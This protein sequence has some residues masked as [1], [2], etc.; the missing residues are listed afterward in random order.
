MSVVPAV[1]VIGPVGVLGIKSWRVQ[2][3]WVALSVANKIVQIRVVSTVP[4][5]RVVHRAGGVIA[6]GS[7]SRTCRPGA[8]RCRLRR[9]TLARFPTMAL[10]DG[11]SL[12]NR[13]SRD[14]WR[15]KDIRR[16]CA[17]H[18]LASSTSADTGFH[19]FS[20]VSHWEVIVTVAVVAV[21]GRGN[22]S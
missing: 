9:T 19:D 13:H 5:G 2:S 17:N 6:R 18:G 16:S 1:V 20:Y 4:P 3:G 21:C 8:T 12:R 15:G 7:R 11:N 22:V 10:S 14:A